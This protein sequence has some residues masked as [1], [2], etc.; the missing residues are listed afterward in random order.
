MNN[1]NAQFSTPFYSPFIP[2]GTI[3]PQLLHPAS[4]FVVASPYGTQQPTS[5]ISSS[6][7]CQFQGG[8]GQPI[9]P[10]SNAAPALNNST[11]NL[12][13]TPEDPTSLRDVPMAPPTTLNTSTNPQ[14]ASQPV[15]KDKDT[16]DYT[17]RTQG[18]YEANPRLG[19]VVHLHGDSRICDDL[20]G[21]LLLACGA[22]DPRYLEELDK[23]ID[24]YRKPVIKDLEATER[25]LDKV[26]EDLSKAKSHIRKLEEEL[27]Q[28]KLA[29]TSTLSKRKKTDGPDAGDGEPR[30]SK[31]P[32]ASDTA[33]IIPTIGFDI[34][35]ANARPDPYVDLT[36]LEHAHYRPGFPL[37]NAKLR[38][39]TFNGSLEIKSHIRTLSQQKQLP[40]PISI[41]GTSFGSQ[42]FPQTAAELAQLGIDAQIAGNYAPLMRAQSIRSL[43]TLLNYL[44]SF[45]NGTTPPLSGTAKDALDLL[46]Y[47]DW[48]RHT[49]FTEY[50]KFVKNEDSPGNFSTNKCEI[51]PVA[52]HPTSSSSDIDFAQAAI[53][54][55][56]PTVDAGI[57]L[58]DSGNVWMNSIR[59]FRLHTSIVPTDVKATDDKSIPH[60]HV[61][62]ITLCA[63]TH[64][65]DEILAKHNLTIAPNRN[66]RP[67]LVSDIKDTITVS[68]YLAECGITVQEIALCVWYALRYCRVLS[69]LAFLRPTLR[70]KYSLIFIAAQHRMLFYPLP[71]PPTDVYHIPEHWDPQGI[72]EYRRRQAVVRH[73]R[74]SKSARHILP[75]KDWKL[76]TINYSRSEPPKAAIDGISTLTLDQDTTMEGA[77][78]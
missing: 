27:V 7:D 67:C 20:F 31:R 38:F 16:G 12:Y 32:A 62:F 25:H 17:S 69:Q 53:V 1:P 77:S 58:D 23:L 52:S 33:T 10:V 37:H 65:Y 43:A 55:F 40:E 59:S 29:S 68:A 13:S 72:L 18:T 39:S 75:D 8:E 46:I 74:N 73:W 49:L 42:S 50:S 3:N 6:P 41:I 45:S 15:T 14:P 21:H 60:F 22:Q 4:S 24:Y 57:I 28:V 54:H 51:P 44:H 64:L 35:D 78:S 76:P 61:V 11:P 66:L 30:P 56:Q 34:I 9:Q 36:L 70:R 48:A 5:N 71:E 63:N 2:H 19:T 26:R 47:P